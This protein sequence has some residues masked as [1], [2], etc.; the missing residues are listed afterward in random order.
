MQQPHRVAGPVH[1]HTSARLLVLVPPAL[2]VHPGQSVAL[3][4]SSG[5]GKSTVVKVCH[6]ARSLALLQFLRVG[7]PT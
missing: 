6:V 7:V 5:G 4:G 2:Q 3:V 1:A